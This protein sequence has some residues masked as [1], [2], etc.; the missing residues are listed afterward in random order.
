MIIQ[1]FSG[2]GHEHSG[3]YVQSF[4]TNAI[5][6]C[7]CVNVNNYQIIQKDISNIS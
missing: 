5:L 1:S 7:Q 6:T 2:K 3:N 4:D